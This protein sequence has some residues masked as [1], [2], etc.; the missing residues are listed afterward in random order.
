MG[1]LRRR[2]T[3]FT[4]ADETITVHRPGAEPVGAFTAA[5]LDGSFGHRLNGQS[6]HITEGFYG[7][8]ALGELGRR[9]AFV[10][11]AQLQNKLHG[12]VGS[13]NTA[14][15]ASKPPT[16]SVPVTAMQRVLGQV[17]PV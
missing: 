2:P 11:A 1:L 15:P 14:A 5:V 10:G 7:T 16:D 3:S 8:R 6:G 12:A 4:P 17:G 9:Q 13:L